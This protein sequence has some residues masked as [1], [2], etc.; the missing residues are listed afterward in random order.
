MEDTVTQVIEQQSDRPKPVTVTVNNRPIV[1]QDHKATGQEIKETAIQ[2]GVT[3]GLDFAL[4]EVKGGG[5]LKPI[6]DDETVI[7]HEGEAF[8]AVAPDDNSQDAA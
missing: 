2:Q 4:F 8:R 6:A 5:N 1:F 3:I 7:L